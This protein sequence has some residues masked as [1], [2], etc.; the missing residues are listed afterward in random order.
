MVDISRQNVFLRVKLLYHD[1]IAPKF[2][3]ERLID[4]QN[5]FR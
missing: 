1:Q 2:V 3:A 5:W 4:S